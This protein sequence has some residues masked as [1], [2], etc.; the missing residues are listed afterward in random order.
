MKTPIVG[1]P[2]RQDADSFTMQEGNAIA[3][4]SRRYYRLADERYQSSEPLMLFT[5][6]PLPIKLTGALHAIAVP[7]Q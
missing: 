1:T 6:D 5:T 3:T 4:Y 2:I 7:S